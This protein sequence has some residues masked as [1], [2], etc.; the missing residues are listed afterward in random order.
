MKTAL[1]T[2]LDIRNK[3]GC[4]GQSV[5]WKDIEHCLALEKQQFIEHH[6]QCVKEGAESEGRK[7]TPEDE[8]FCKLHSENYFNKT[9]FK[10]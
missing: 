4:L 1:Q 3:K 2:F 9:F 7:V 5:T 10:K 8:A 6:T